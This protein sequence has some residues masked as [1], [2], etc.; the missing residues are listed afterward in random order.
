M[1]LCVRG[2][3]LPLSV[4]ILVDFGTVPTVFFCNSFY[5]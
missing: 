2:V 3:G 4:I 5:M 1:Y